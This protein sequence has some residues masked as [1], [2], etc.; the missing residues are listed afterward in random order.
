[1]TERFLLNI[2][3][4]SMLK[5]VMTKFAYKVASYVFKLKILHKSDWYC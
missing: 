3:V 2:K 5:F 4:V 1:M